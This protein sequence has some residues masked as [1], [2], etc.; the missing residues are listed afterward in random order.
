MFSNRP[1]EARSR[2]WSG[3]KSLDVR[4]W[5]PVKSL[6]VRS[7]S[8]RTKLL[9]AVLV[10]FAVVSVSVGAVSTV[11]LRHFLLGRLDDQLSAAADRAGGPGSQFPGGPGP[12]LDSG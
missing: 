3:T 5:S 4:S 1:T 2:R 9:A 6:D 7:W 11:A 10:L 8:L 12:Q